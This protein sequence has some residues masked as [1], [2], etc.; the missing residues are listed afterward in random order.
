MKSIESTTKTYPKTT[1]FIR[2]YAFA[3]L[4]GPISSISADRA[5]DPV[6]EARG[7]GGDLALRSYGKDRV[8]G[9]LEENLARTLAKWADGNDRSLSGVVTSF[10]EKGRCELV[11]WVRG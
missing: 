7:R 1:L 4:R 8:L 6:A 10:R 3:P 11:F 2:L 9:G 5:Q